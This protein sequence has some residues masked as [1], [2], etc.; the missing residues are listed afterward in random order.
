MKSWAIAYLAELLKTRACLAKSSV[1]G[2]NSVMAAHIVE[3]NTGAVGEAARPS[4]G[5]CL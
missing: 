1:W 3:K 2:A 5:C 4:R